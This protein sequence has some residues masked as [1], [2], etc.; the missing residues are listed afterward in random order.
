[1]M[2]LNDIKRDIIKNQ[3]EQR[4]GAKETEEKQKKTRQVEEIIVL[5]R[6]SKMW[7]VMGI[8]VE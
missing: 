7:V 2:K 3:V 4:K 6:I 1:M 8:I 5:Q